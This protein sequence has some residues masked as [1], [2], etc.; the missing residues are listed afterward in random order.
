MMRIIIGY[1]IVIELN[2]S[3]SNRIITGSPNLA[4]HMF[5]F[6]NIICNLV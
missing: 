5:R 6:Q 1:R 3:N 2:N 4:I